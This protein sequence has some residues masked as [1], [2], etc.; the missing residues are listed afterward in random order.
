[1]E[2]ASCVDME[3][4]ARCLDELFYDEDFVS[5]ISDIGSRED[6]REYLANNGVV[7]SSEEYTQ[8]CAYIEAQNG[9][10]LY[11]DDL[12][13]VIGGAPLEGAMILQTALKCFKMLAGIFNRRG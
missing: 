4:I 12:D 10:E 1:M 11:E 8:M 3:A 13:G 7:L 5:G 9:A 2:G 6:F